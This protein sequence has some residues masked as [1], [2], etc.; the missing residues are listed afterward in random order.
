MP[1]NLLHGF[2]AVWGVLGEET[3]PPPGFWQF[4]WRSP[5]FQSLRHLPPCNWH[6][7]SYFPGVEPRSGWVCYVL[8]PCRPFKWRKSSS[9]FHRPSPHW[10]LQTEVMGLYLPSAGTL[11]CVVWP[12]AGIA[13]SQGVPPAHCAAAVT[14]TFPCHTALCP[15]PRLHPSCSSG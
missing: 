4:T 12:S 11:G 13:H 5:S 15:S 6:P 7:S 3:V 8:R 14:S 1:A 2:V 9:F 10:F